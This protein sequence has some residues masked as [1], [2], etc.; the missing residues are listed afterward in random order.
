MLVSVEFVVGDGTYEVEAEVEPADHGSRITAPCGGRIDVK[1]VCAIPGTVG[2][3]PEVFLA[4]LAREDRER[5]YSY[6]AQA[7][8]EAEPHAG[9][10]RDEED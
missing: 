2:I 8:A 4:D 1:R 9:D 6:L 10:A 7:A 5:L 3:G